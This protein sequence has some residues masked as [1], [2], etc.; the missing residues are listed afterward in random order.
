[1]SQRVSRGF[2]RL[3][4]FLA[5]IVPL[6]ACGDDTTTSTLSLSG[7]VRFLVI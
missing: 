2:Q 3:A 1:M 4:L 7:P 5:T 6:A